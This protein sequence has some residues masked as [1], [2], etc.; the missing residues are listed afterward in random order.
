VGHLRRRVGEDLGVGVGGGT[1]LV[2][3]V[4]EQVGGAPQRD[5]PGAL[6][7]LGGPVDHL[8]EQRCRLLERAALGCDV[9]VVEAVVGHAELGEELEGRV[10][11]LARRLHR[12]GGGRERR[13][14]GAVERPRAEDVE[15]VPG[16]RVPV[17]DREAEVVLHAPA[18]HHA[19]GVVPVEGQRLVA[20]GAQVGDPLGDVGEELGHGFPPGA[21]VTVTLPS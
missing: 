11:L 20:V 10:H 6:L 4:G 13:M 7:V 16:E 14:P 9:A 8:V 19:V 1:G 5:Q 21:Q 2:A 17:A 18:G 3:G 12:V 15:A